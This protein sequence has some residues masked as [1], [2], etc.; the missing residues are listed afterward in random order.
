MM[1]AV[2]TW[3]PGT[4]YPGDGS[5]VEVLA[6]GAR[7]ETDVVRLESNPWEGVGVVV[8]VRVKC[9][10]IVEVRIYNGSGRSVDLQPNRLRVFVGR[11][12]TVLLSEFEQLRADRDRLRAIVRRAA[13]RSWLK[14]DERQPP[15]DKAMCVG[16]GGYLNPHVGTCGGTPGTAPGQCWV[17]AVLALGG[18]LHVYRHPEG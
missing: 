2:V 11:T 4:L 17:L 10:D 6:Q 5:Q 15:T 3:D 8:S 9:A 12:T 7:P 1:E 18:W 16:C 14:V 13:E